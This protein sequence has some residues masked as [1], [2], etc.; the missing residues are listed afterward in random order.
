M[1]RAGAYANTNITPRVQCQ[2][3]SLRPRTL[4]T[5]RRCI[6]SGERGNRLMFVQAGR[7]VSSGPA[8]RRTSVSMLPGT[9]VMCGIPHSTATRCRALPATARV[10][11]RSG[12]E[13]VLGIVQLRPSVVRISTF[14]G[15]VRRLANIE[16]YGD[17]AIAK[18]KD[19]A[20]AGKDRVKCNPPSRFRRPPQLRFY[21]NPT[22]VVHIYIYICTLILASRVHVYS[23]TRVHRVLARTPC[24]HAYTCTLAAE[25]VHGW[26]R[27]RKCQSLLSVPCLR[28]EHLQASRRT[29]VARRR[30]AELRRHGAQRTKCRSMRVADQA[31]RVRKS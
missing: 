24:T 16:F 5:A 23:S 22:S 19:D 7:N 17:Y 31:C 2:W 13:D 6:N 20:G 4:A 11:S 14:C 18:G 25:A 29:D 28:S 12:F 21:G 10:L 1:G 8:K 30:G 3:Y 26:V 27:A 15:A 9:A